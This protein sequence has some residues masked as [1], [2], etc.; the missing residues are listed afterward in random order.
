VLGGF[1]SILVVA[2][3]LGAADIQYDLL[4][5]VSS[6]LFSE[7]GLLSVFTGRWMLVDV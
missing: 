5:H 4:G 6:F 7:P 2:I 3:I 1:A